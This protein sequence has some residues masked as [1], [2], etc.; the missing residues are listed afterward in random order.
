MDIIIYEIETFNTPSVA[1]V[2][3]AAVHRGGLRIGRLACR[4]RSR[5]IAHALTVVRAVA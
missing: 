3:W 5:S 4:G 2:Y 1:T